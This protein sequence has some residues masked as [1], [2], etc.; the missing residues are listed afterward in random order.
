MKTSGDEGAW[1]V[2]GYGIETHKL[3]ER[4][5]VN[6]KKPE[7]DRGVLFYRFEVFRISNPPFLYDYFD[8]L[9]EMYAVPPDTYPVTI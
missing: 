3:A 5:Q 7:G 9:V 6:G 2:G 1:V 8:A 4:I